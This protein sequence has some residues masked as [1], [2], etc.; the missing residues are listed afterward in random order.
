MEY[1]PVNELIEH[2][3]AGARPGYLAKG[4]SLHVM[5]SRRDPAVL[6]DSDRLGQVIGI[7]L[8]N[9]LRHT[10]PGVEVILAVVVPDQR[11]ANANP[12][13]G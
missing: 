11:N 3:A 5:P 8:D 12:T 13:C 9:A 2:A 7:L 6:V 1:N 10:P 4:V